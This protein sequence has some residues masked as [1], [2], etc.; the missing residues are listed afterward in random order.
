[1]YPTCAVVRDGVCQVEE[2]TTCASNPTTSTQRSPNITTSMMHGPDAERRVTARARECRHVKV[3]AEPC[4]NDDGA[5][6][7]RAH[8]QPR[9]QQLAR[10]SKKKMRSRCTRQKQI[11][12]APSRAARG[13]CASRPAER[14]GVTSQSCAL[15]ATRLRAIINPLDGAISRGNCARCER[16]CVV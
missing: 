13:P 9:A 6:E 5:H 14:A 7:G 10:M 4:A 16:H 2:C 11:T 12:R 3:A 15:F 1:M 8:A